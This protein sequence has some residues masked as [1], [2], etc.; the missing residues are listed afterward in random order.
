MEPRKPG[1]EDSEG[2]DVHVRRPARDLEAAILGEEADRVDVV[3]RDVAPR[4]VV[5]PFAGEQGKVPDP[6]GC[7]RVEG[8][9]RLQVVGMVEATVLDAGSVLERVEVALDPPSE[10][11]PAQCRRRPGA[12]LAFGH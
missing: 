12:G 4:R 9:A 7:D 2:P 10:L 3:L 5:R 8:E 6:E 11:V 1:R